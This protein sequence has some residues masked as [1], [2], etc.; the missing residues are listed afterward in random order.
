MVKHS[1]FQFSLS[2]AALQI[3]SQQRIHPFQD[4]QMAPEGPCIFITR[5]KQ[6]QNDYYFTFMYD[7]FDSHFLYSAHSIYEVSKFTLFFFFFFSLSKSLL[8]LSAQQSN[9]QTNKTLLL[10]YSFLKL[11]FFKDN[12]LVQLCFC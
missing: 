6:K 7:T 1:K 10:L 11:H 9:F 12:Y 5:T 4:S 3:K 2:Y 8:L